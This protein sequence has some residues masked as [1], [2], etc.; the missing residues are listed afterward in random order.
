MWSLSFTYS[1][2]DR[3]TKPKF[4]LKSA[5]SQRRRQEGY[6]VVDGITAEE[7]E[8]LV[9]SEEQFEELGNLRYQI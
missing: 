1:L 3:A 8:Q 5:G 9:T 2:V 7:Q 6:D 4:S